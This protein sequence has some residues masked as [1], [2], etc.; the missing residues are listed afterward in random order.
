MDKQTTLRSARKRMV[1]ILYRDTK[2]NEKKVNGQVRI[3]TDKLC[4]V[5]NIR[6]KHYTVV[7]LDGISEVR[8]NKTKT[9]FP[10]VIPVTY[11]A[12]PLD[13]FR[14]LTMPFTPAPFKA[15]V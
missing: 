5:R 2:G 8:A 10:S 1:S 11:S 7:L 9:Q 4:I 6:T 3:C 15:L 14:F 12:V 13:G